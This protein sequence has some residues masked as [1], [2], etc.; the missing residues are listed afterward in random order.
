VQPAHVAHHHVARAQQQRLKPRLA[1]LD[2]AQALLLGQHVRGARHLKRAILLGH[3]DE[4]EVDRELERRRLAPPLGKERRRVTV[5][6]LVIR[7]EQRR[8]GG[9]LHH[10]G[11]FAHQPAH[12]AEHVVILEDLGVCER[13][14]ERQRHVVTAGPAVAPVPLALDVPLQQRREGR[15]P[16]PH[17]LTREVARQ[18]A[19]PVL[20][21]RPHERLN[22]RLAVTTHLLKHRVLSAE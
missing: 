7:A 16:R 11:V 3:V 10:R 9:E 2:A 13:R 5:N 18:H 6:V 1:R 15:A 21:H 17:L 22:L 20:Q 12:D 4:R 19:E 14:D 8:V